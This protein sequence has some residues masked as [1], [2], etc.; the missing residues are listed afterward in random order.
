MSDLVQLSDL[1]PWPPQSGATRTY[2]AMVKPVGAICNIDCTYCYYLHKEKL[3]GSKSKF[4]ISDVILETHIRQHI[5]GQDRDE[6]VFS[7]QGGEPTLLGLEFLHKVAEL[8]Q[9]YKKPGQRIENDL[10]TNS[11]LLHDD[12]GAFLKQPGFLVG[13][14]IDGPEELHDHY[15]VTKE[16]KPT[17]DKVFAASQR[18]HRHGVPFNC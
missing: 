14:S 16:G 4:Q 8:E 9:K 7:W 6:V 15:H 1:S 10:Q 17:F 5:K 12:W 2:H 11:T 18:L 3:L 13:L